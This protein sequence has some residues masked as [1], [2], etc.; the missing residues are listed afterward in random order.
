MEPLWS[1][2]VA[3]GNNQWQ[4]RRA[5]KFLHLAQLLRRYVGITPSCWRKLS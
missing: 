4:V 3:T 2:V 5:R 1:P